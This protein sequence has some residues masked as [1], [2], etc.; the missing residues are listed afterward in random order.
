MTT[1][2][3][4]SGRPILPFLA[5]DSSRAGSAHSS[6][7]LEIRDRTFLGNR[8]NM[9]V[10]PQPESESAVGGLLRRDSDQ[11]ASSWTNR[12]PAARPARWPS[13]SSFH[14]LGRQNPVLCSANMPT[15]DVQ[16]SLSR[17]QAG[18]NCEDRRTDFQQQI[19]RLFV[20]ADQ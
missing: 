13:R 17:F 8:S 4:P 20:R 18:L 3:S 12:T 19:R 1:R 6:L 5:S 10:P 14:V 2:L 15:A 11:G 16:P 9:G 7:I